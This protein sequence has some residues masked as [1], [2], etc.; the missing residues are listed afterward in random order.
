MYYVL[1]F[2]GVTMEEK[3][4]KAHRKIWEKV[5]GKIPKNFDIHHIDNNKYNNNINNLLM[6]PKKLHNDYHKITYEIK[7]L[8]ISCE[9]KSVIDSGN[10]YNEYL[11]NLHKQLYITLK[12]CNKWAD[13]KQFLLGNIPNIHNIN[14]E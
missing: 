6:L 3:R 10:R 8:K 4:G 7:D 12:E 2:L 1:Y 11:F 13:Y 14:M 5:I 9:I